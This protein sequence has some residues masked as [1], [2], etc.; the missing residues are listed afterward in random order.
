M[1]IKGTQRTGGLGEARIYRDAWEAAASVPASGWR[2]WQ[3]AGV[4]FSRFHVEGTPFELPFRPEDYLWAGPFTLKMPKSSNRWGYYRR[5]VK[6]YLNMLAKGLKLPPVLLLQ[7]AWGWA[8]ED[9]SHRFEALMKAGA[10][11]Y[12]AFLGRPKRM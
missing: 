4:Q 9:G 11:T 7:R 10:A 8:L 3:E 1:T 12:D 5:G 6:K 2:E